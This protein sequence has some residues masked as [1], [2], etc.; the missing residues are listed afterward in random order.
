M[1]QYL[2]PDEIIKMYLQGCTIKRL[3]FYVHSSRLF[4]KKEKSREY[5]ERTIFEYH[6]KQ[7]QN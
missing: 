4:T 5:V 1:E 6:M 2:K 7:K 3:T